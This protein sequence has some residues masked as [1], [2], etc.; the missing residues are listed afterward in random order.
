MTSVGLSFVSAAWFGLLSSSDATRHGLKRR[1]RQKGGRGTYTVERGS[2][3]ES[4]EVE[5]RQV[6]GDRTRRLALPVIMGALD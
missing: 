5:F 6:R 3:A 4:G 2:G 1:S